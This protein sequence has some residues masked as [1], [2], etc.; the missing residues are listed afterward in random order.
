[1]KAKFGKIGYKP[2]SINSLVITGQD[3]EIFNKLTDD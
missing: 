3:D 2:D 1:M